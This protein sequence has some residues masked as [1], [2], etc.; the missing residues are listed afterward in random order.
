[1]YART[2]LDQLIGLLVHLVIRQGK[3]ERNKVLGRLDNI[4]GLYYCSLDISTGLGRD[5]SL[6]VCIEG[7]RK[8]VLLHLVLLLVLLL[9]GDALGLASLLV[10][11]GLVGL[12]DLLLLLPQLLIGI[13]GA[14]THGGLVGSGFGS[15]AARRF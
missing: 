1:M 10:L 2:L 5:V 8:L 14:G 7:A 11:L 12:V 4:P 6:E 3:R 15:G 13:F 9:L